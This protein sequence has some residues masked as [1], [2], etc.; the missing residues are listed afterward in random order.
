[1]AG[2]GQELTLNAP[3]FL[4][5]T[6]AAFIGLPYLS[7][8]REHGIAQLARLPWWG[9]PSLLAGC[10]LLIIVVSPPGIP[11]FIYYQF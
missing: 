2:T 3:G 7:A 4:A 5:L 1:M 8:A 6:A 10:A 11:G 9:K